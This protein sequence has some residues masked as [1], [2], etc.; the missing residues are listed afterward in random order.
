MHAARARG[1]GTGGGRWRQWPRSGHRRARTNRRDS[2]TP[3]TGRPGSARPASATESL[4]RSPAGRSRARAGAGGGETRAHRPSFSAPSWPPGAP[5]RRLGRGRAQLG[6]SRDPESGAL[7]LALRPLGGWGTDGH[8]TSR[9]R[10]LP[11]TPRCTRAHN[12][13]AR[14]VRSA[15]PARPPALSVSR[16][17]S[18]P[19]LRSEE[20]SREGVRLPGGRGRRGKSH[21]RSA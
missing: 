16:A 6:L 12:A 10:S 9:E 14:G 2:P 3:S 8:R 7:S 13:R 21:S 15:P 11:R 5:S 4:F 20:G 17:R 19:S 18:P 1:P